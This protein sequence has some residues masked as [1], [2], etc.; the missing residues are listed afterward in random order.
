MDFA[1][2]WIEGSDYARTLGVALEA[3]A[4][5]AARIALPFAEGNTNPG[6]VLH[7]GVAASL[8][9][10]AAQAVARATLGAEAA[11]FT[12]ASL[13]VTYLAAA[14]EQAV[15]A[16]ARRLRAGKELVFVDVA[17]RADDGRE[18]AQGL[19]AVRGAFGSKPSLP[20]AR[21]DDG[22]ADPG[23]MGPHIAKTPFMG[24]LG[25]AVEHMTGGTSRIALP[26]RASLRDAAGGLH[27]GAALALLD[28]T[29]AMAAW[30]VTG[31][32]RFKASTPALHAE[33]LA[34]PP[35][36]DVVG[37]GRSVH[38]DAEAHW[39]DVELAGAASRRV[40]ARG[41]VLYRIVT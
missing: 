20:A 41:S 10:L 22:A 30:A 32:G 13:Q 9:S 7:G 19:A 39:C 8:V 34:P 11:P 18:I 6:G 16:E 17:V 29:G 3:I 37:Y 12:S 40:F 23:P 2:A 4:P 5:E 28:T 15:V 24:R 36:E 1:R 38:R 21:G 14:K 26:L 25:L 35:A 31:P 27:E 33:L